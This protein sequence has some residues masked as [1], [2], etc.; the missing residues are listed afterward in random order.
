[1]SARS[2]PAYSHPA[3]VVDTNILMALPAIHKFNWGMQPVTVYVLDAVVNELRGLARNKEDDAKAATARRALSVLDDLQKCAQ[4]DGIPLPN[5]TGHLIFAQAPSDIS[6][7]LDPD[8]VDH[9]QIALAQAHLKASPRSFCAIV[10]NDQE[11][12]DIAL[13]ASPSVPVIAPG[14]GA[15]KR[16]IRR[17]LARRRRWWKLFRRETV[18]E[19]PHPV[20]SARPAPSSRADRQARLEQVV[21]SL[22]GR[23]RSARHRAILSIAPLEARLALTAHL[24]RILTRH[25]NRAI[26]LFVED[27]SE[28]KYWADELRQ[29]CKLRPDAV[30][31][32]GERGIPQV[33][34]TR[35]VVYRHPQI[36]SR[37]NQHAARF[38]K[39]GRHVTAVVDG[40]DLLDPVWIA[41]LLFGCGQFI[42]FTR[43]SLGHAQAVG[44]R[45]LATF[46]Q[47]QTVATYTF[48]DA[49]RSDWLRP[50]DV[51]RHSVAFQEDESQSYR[52]VNNQFIAVHSQVSRR[53]P[54]LNEAS[55]FWGALRRV[56]ERA[57]DH[58][59][60]SLFMLRERREELAQRARAKCEVVVR[61]LSEI[62]SPARCLVCD[63]EQLW[64]TAL[65][66]ALADRE[67]TVEVLE[68]SSNAVVR[69]SLWHRFK[70]GKVDCL[71]LQNVPPSG[72]VGTRINRL[73]IMTPL[74]PLSRLAAIVDWALSHAVSGPTTYV[75]L[76]Y[77][78]GTPE[79]RAMMDFADTCCGLRFGR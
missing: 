3:V 7:P 19:R 30:L 75:D 31:V 57:V 12:T 35:V 38:T 37:F 8:N 49:E 10:T 42:G 43:H 50:F 70:A 45:M 16:A 15:I 1:M 53:Y 55:D 65:L 79:Q 13:S 72:L 22:Y 21:C 60:A 71:I 36:E 67:M 24:V 26:F 11:M 46:F 33:Q 9:Q 62:R 61:L 58:Q 68:R 5:S 44:G 41:M 64:T 40:C 18:A 56:L 14:S 23:L 39:A 73:I 27:Q 32:F 29:R 2:R 76:L 48:A 20:K 74:T 54:E 6:P 77:T 52:E 17:Q 4:P 78:S 66:E 69:E 51:L 63:L 47:Q 25:E 34:G 28:A 59:A